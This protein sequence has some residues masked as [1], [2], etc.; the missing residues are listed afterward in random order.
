MYERNPLF[1]IQKDRF[2]SLLSGPALFTIYMQHWELYKRDLIPF[3]VF[4]NGVKTVYPM[5]GS[6]DLEKM[7]D[8]LAGFLI[9]MTEL[10]T[11][12]DYF[13]LVEAAKVVCN[14]DGD[15]VFLEMLKVQQ[16]IIDQVRADK[17]PGQ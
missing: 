3:Q 14:Y 16:K 1:D 15:K 7:H 5:L 13:R 11:K 9:Q 10:D 4:E 6:S 12:D 17:F 2:E 8:S